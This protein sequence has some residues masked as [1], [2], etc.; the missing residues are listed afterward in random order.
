VQQF[1]LVWFET[2]FREFMAKSKEWK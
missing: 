2:I 1:Q